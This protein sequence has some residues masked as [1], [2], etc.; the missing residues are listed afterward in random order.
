MFDYN[1][2]QNLSPMKS[3]FLSKSDFKAAFEC[4]T[5]L[6]YRKNQYPSTVDDDQF[7][8]CLAEGGFMVEEIAHAAFPS[9]MD[10]SG[11][12]DH[13]KARELTD[14]WLLNCDEGAL[15]EGCVMHGNMLARI[16]ILYKK[17]GVLHLIE[18][19]SS[20]IAPNIE[21]PWKAFCGS[22]GEINS[23][24]RP[25]LLDVTF[26]LMI[27]RAS[28]KDITIS[29]HL[30]TVDKTQPANEFETLG[31]FKLL[32]NHSNPK[33]R[34]EISY[35]GNPTN[36]SRSKL[37]ARTDVTVLTDRL[38]EEVR[39]RA[40][41]LAASLNTGDEVQRIEPN[42]VERYKVCRT[43]EYRL[44]GASN[45][46][47]HGFAECWGTL[48]ESS[49]HILDLYQVSK[50]GSAHFPDPV[51]D[52]MRGGQASYLELQPEQLGSNDAVFAQRRRIQR[53]H[54]LDQ[55]EWFSDELKNQLLEHQSNPG[56]PLYFI[57]F[58]A[59]NVVLP[60]HEGMKPFERVAFQWSCHSLRSADGKLEHKEW[61]NTEKDFPNFRFV[62]S[63][64][65]C[66]GDEG[67][68]YVWSDFESQTLIRI[69][70]QL[71][72][73]PE[74]F[75]SSAIRSSREDLADW[76]ATLLGPSDKNGKY[77][78]SPRIRD[79]H[80]FAKSHYF[81]PDMLGRT[82]IKVVLPSIWKHQ[83][84]IRNHPWFAEYRRE[85][86]TLGW[87]E[88]I[89]YTGDET[90]EDTV[91]DGTGA[92]RVYQQLLF[93]V[94]LDDSARENHKKLLLQYCKLD[95]AAMVMIWLHWIG[96]NHQSFNSI[97]Q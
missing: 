30:W 11:E 48:A 29:A 13:E 93:V 37:I 3:N 83:E 81:H 43:C 61:I 12:R 31:Q 91:S 85:K 68:V 65:E 22:K 21:E 52:L 7:L 26:Q 74:S 59:C 4:G 70:Q 72:M 96:G 56:W 55:S 2:I 28:W 92:I 39:E 17:D 32:R 63:L 50:I 54:T 87:D 24:W 66:L 62:E 1:L 76:I 6:F 75:G 41:V 64:R 95:T 57:D 73:P 46:S 71:R 34:P 42:I 77:R 35:E 44:K 89:G 20:S 47:K 58:E 90:E 45:Q 25:Y 8:R 5:K 84:Q 16:D 86:G 78:H 14:Q 33:A 19:K 9:A 18:V 79:L 80:D 38:M 15:F 60:H 40:E 94:D 49:P 27:A 82:S 51:P 69:L 67:T 10:L 88:P 36:L 97:N 53:Q 23:N